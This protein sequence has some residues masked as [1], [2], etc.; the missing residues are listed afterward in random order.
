MDPVKARAVAQ[1]FVAALAAKNP[2]AW[3]ALFDPDRG[4]NVDP[5]HPLPVEGR[6]ALE[7]HAQNLMAALKDA[8]ITPLDVLA[9]GDTAAIRWVAHAPAPS[10][11][12]LEAVSW[13]HLGAEAVLEARTLMDGAAALLFPNG[14]AEVLPEVSAQRHGTELVL[15]AVDSR[16]AAFKVEQLR[17]RVVC[18][19]CASRRVQSA[20]QQV[21]EAL[22]EAF[23]GNDQVV[24]VLLLD[25]S[26]VP[27]ALRPVARGALM[28]LRAQVMRRFHE[29]FA[30]LRRPTPAHVE[31]LAWLLPDFDGTLLKGLGVALP[32]DQPVLMVLDRAG[33]L[34][35]QWRAPA[36]E[37]AVHAVDAVRRLL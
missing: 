20:V 30:R 17:G 1:A 12:V 25:G 4:R 19:L 8:V 31:E 5:T 9:E 32:L 24:L 21:A 14:A 36:E 2:A 23:G 29:G 27:V 6:A 11:H 7:A 22:G 28:A 37:T 26:D 15:H 13:L 18:L 10:D 34:H 33:R 16:G 35:R 3:C